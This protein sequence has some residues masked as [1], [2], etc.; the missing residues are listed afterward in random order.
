MEFRNLP[1]LHYTIEQTKIQETRHLDTWKH[2]KWAFKAP[3][4]FR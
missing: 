4:Q 2:M 1:A 3:F